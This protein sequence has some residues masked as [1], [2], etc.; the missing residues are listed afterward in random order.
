MQESLLQ[1][2][3]W[4]LPQ[5]Y[6]TYRLR[7]LHSQPNPE[8]VV[9]LDNLG[10]GLRRAW[11]PGAGGAQRSEAR[12]LRLQGRSVPHLQPAAQDLHWCHTIHA[13]ACLHQ[14]TYKQRT[15]THMHAC[16]AHARTRVSTPINSDT[17]VRGRAYTPIN[18]D[19]SSTDTHTRTD[20]RTRARARTHTS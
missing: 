3:P 15:H 8:A 17:R 1:P 10:P 11:E 19:A 13:L 14:R 4:P 2:Q 6:N 12:T 16:F 5:P 18:S 7:L 20:L 9:S